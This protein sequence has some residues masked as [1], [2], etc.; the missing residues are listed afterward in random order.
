MRWGPRSRERGSP[1]GSTGTTS[2]AGTP[3]GIWPCP[4]ES[5]NLQGGRGR[6]G[7]APLFSVSAFCPHP[8]LCGTVVDNRAG[9]RNPRHHQKGTTMNLSDLAIHADTLA[10]FAAASPDGVV[11]V[12][13]TTIEEVQAPAGTRLA[14]AQLASGD[15]VAVELDTGRRATG[16]VHTVAGD[17][18]SF[19]LD[20]ATGAA[21]VA[22][23]NIAA[24]ISLGAAEDVPT[25]SR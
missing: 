1:P 5:L 21:L 25:T 7:R 6:A 17:A 2:G 20:T 4:I 15:R 18:S 24:I 14:A 8:T 12:V 13:D 19:V 10:L 16:T 22:A 11:E 3:P 9:E 23:Q